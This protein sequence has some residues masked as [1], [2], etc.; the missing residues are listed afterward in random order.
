MTLAVASSTAR[1]RCSTTRCWVVSQGMDFTTDK[2]RSLVR[3]WQTL[4][5][6]HVDVKTTDGYVLR[7][8]C[9]SFTKKRMGQAC[10]LACSVAIWRW[11]PLLPR[12]IQAGL[13]THLKLQAS[14]TNSMPAPALV[15][16]CTENYGPLTLFVARMLQVKK[17]CY[18]QTSQIRLIRKK[19]VEIM[20]REASS[21]DLK[22]LVGKFIP[23]SIGALCCPIQSLPVHMANWPAQTFPQL[24]RV[25][26]RHGVSLGV[27]PS[28]LSQCCIMSG[29][30][31]TGSRPYRMEA[32]A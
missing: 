18:A 4:I 23:E 29:S 5:E 25:L 13:T 8:F 2:L 14:D 26:L 24:L 22:E 3:K 9:I 21:C 6:A 27:R 11:H 20:T 28:N 31:L 1:C 16:V 19:M 17:T 32:R 12:G 30:R 15:R 7:L 10:P